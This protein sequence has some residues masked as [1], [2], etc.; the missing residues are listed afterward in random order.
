MAK[1]FRPEENRAYG[2][3]EGMEVDKRDRNN[4]MICYATAAIAPKTKTTGSQL[5]RQKPPPCA[6]DVAAE[7]RPAS[8]WGADQW[9]TRRTAA[10]VPPRQGAS[11]KSAIDLLLLKMGVAELLY[12]P[13]IP[14]KVT[15]NEYIEIAKN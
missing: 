2:K 9:A 13:T 15:I 3:R 14:T 12:F 5:L 7:P 1:F 11:R 8:G 6:V 10:A 4:D